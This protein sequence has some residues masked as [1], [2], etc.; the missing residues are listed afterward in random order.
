M[1]SQTLLSPIIVEV[2]RAKF[3]TADVVGNSMLSPTAIRSVLTI[4]MLGISVQ[5]PLC[6]FSSLSATLKRLVAI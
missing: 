6:P 4:P 2:G 5:V 3:I 1:I